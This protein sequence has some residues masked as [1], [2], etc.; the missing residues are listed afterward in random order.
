MTSLRYAAFH[1]VLFPHTADPEPTPLLHVSPM[2]K[3]FYMHHC[4][5]DRIYSKYIEIE[6]LAHP[7]PTTQL[8]LTHSRTLMR[9]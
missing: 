5:I 2:H 3:V 1:P 7:A 4:N 9:S 6:G 8:T